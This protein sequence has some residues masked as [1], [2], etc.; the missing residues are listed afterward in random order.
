[1]GVSFLRFVGND[2][3]YRLRTRARAKEKY[4]KIYIYIYINGPHQGQ[5]CV[6][7]FLNI[8]LKGEL[9]TY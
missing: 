5:S 1:M 6:Y 3:L 9:P 8:F 7:F 2:F 4:N